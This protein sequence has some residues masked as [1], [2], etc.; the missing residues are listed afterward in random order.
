MN[1]LQL[2]EENH[3]S[4]NFIKIQI[5]LLE[6]TRLS[7]PNTIQFN[8]L[9]KQILHFYFSTNILII[10]AFLSNMSTKKGRRTKRRRKGKKER[11][12][13]RKGSKG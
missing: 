1:K 7:R 4:Q 5:R 8:G 3:Q 6:N 11:K 9:V 13:K 10:N 2:A 12:R